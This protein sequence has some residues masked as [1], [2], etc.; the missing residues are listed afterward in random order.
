MRKLT[1][2]QNLVVEFTSDRPHILPSAHAS[3]GFTFWENVR[4]DIAQCKR[5]ATQISTREDV[6]PDAFGAA[7]PAAQIIISGPRPK[8]TLL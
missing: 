1:G 8:V 7:A 6:V 2:F 4:S 5:I 3:H